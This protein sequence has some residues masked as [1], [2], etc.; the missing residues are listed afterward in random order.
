M[1]TSLQ[2]GKYILQQELGV[3]GFG[4]T[5][6]AINQ[7]LNQVVVIKTWKSVLRQKTELAEVRKELL[8][9]AQRLI[10]CDHPNIVRFYEFFIEAEIPYIVMDYIAGETLDEIVQPESV[11]SEAKAIEYIRQLGAALKVIHSNGLLHRD[12]KP[13]NVILHQE[14]QKV[15]LID[16]GIAREFNQG[17]IQT[18]TSIVSDGYAPIEQYLPK[19]PR[20]SATDIYG[21]AAT[22]YTLVTGEIPLPAPLRNRMTLSTPKDMRPELS[23]QISEAIMQGM[24]LEIEERP[25]NIDEWLSWLPQQESKRGSGSA[26]LMGKKSQVGNLVAVRHEEK[27]LDYRKQMSVGLII[28]AVIGWGFD[29]AWLRFQSFSS[30][31]KIELNSRKKLSP[32]VSTPKAEPITPQKTKL[33]KSM[34]VPG[35]VVQ[36]VVSTPQVKP[37]TPPKTKPE[38][39]TTVPKT[40]IQ[41]VVST[42][43]V[44]PITP[45]KT[46]PKKST[47]LP[48]A[49]V[50]P[51]VSTPKAQP[52]TPPK[53][54][55]E[56][57]T[58]VPKTV[59]QPVVS[60]PKVQPITPQKT[61][62]EKSIPIP[63]IVYSPSE[64]TSPQ[65][66]SSDNSTTVPTIIYS[67]SEQTSPNN[68]DSSRSEINSRS[69]SVEIEHQPDKVKKIENREIRVIRSRREQITRSRREQITRSRREQIIRRR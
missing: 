38:K 26:G 27:R 2:N 19:A 25:S 55:P 58:T 49:V 16:F 31:K 12:I 13:Q 57:F 62:P 24:A 67:S 33:E 68:N 50:Q 3:G 37:I 32:V 53:T 64:Q 35:T 18:H 43:K 60:T 9:E 17:R 48:E 14:S 30:Q 39:S 40:V 61:K 56:K 66:N 41:P 22:L 63:T 23:H 47:T 59:V 42:P 69:S 4:R 45:Q 15:V 29:Y 7:V 54:Q 52:I 36:P 8:N 46:K 21:L 51:V 6:K 5:Y 11:L 10:K 28:L 44:Q 1:G 20:T 34:T 65:N